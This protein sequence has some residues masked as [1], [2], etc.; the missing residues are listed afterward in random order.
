MAS[1]LFRLRHLLE[2]ESRRAA[3]SPP[4]HPS[5]KTRPTVMWMSRLHTDRGD[6]L[7]PQLQASSATALTF[8]LKKLNNGGGDVIGPNM[9]I[10]TQQNYSLTKGGTLAAGK[11]RPNLRKQQHQQQSVCNGVI[12][13]ELR[14]LI[15][16]LDY[17]GRSSASSSAR[18]RKPTFYWLMFSSS[19][20]TDRIG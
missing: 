14:H 18:Q 4:T 1:S 7:S 20:R 9:G 17:R 13:D 5:T 6:G 8:E 15:A 2:P 3:L 10:F 19:L 12:Q 16:R 11:Y